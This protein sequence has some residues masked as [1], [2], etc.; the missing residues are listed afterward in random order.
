MKK[1]AA[2]ILAVCLAAGG[3]GENNKTPAKDDSTVFVS[4]LAKD[5]TVNTVSNR[6][7]MLVKISEAQGKKIPKQ[8]F[9]YW[10]NATAMKMVPAMVAS[11]RLDRMLEERKVF[12]TP[13]SDAAILE[14]YNRLFKTEFKTK[15][16]MAESLG[17]LGD[18]FLEQFGYE[19]RLEQ[20]YTTSPLFQIR[21]R[22]RISYYN[23]MTNRIN[24]ARE[25]NRSTEQKAKETYDRLVATGNWD[26]IA[27]KTTEEGK[28]G[29]DAAKEFWREWDS[30]EL[31]DF[32]PQALAEAVARLSPGQFTPP[33]LTDEGI[34]IVRFI[35]KTE[36]NL[37]KCARILFE[38]AIEPIV[39]PESKLDQF[40]I[41][42]KHANWQWS[43]R[44]EIKEAYPA[45]FPLGTNFVYKIWKEPKPLRK[46][47]NPMQ[48]Q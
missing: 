32:K 43:V 40:L 36:D 25:K 6:V 1:A 11:I 18:T 8:M 33:I 14:K 45:K 9:P 26:E 47:F 27:S 17:P 21:E 28:E 29:D 7:M 39:V 19:S 24:A 30:L 16:E 37:Y 15:A 13:V 35:E 23:S 31:K 34:V 20:W 48:L 38:L 46:G 22:D 2:V 41:L 10:A 3:C 4:V 12:P 42:K 44:D 5:I